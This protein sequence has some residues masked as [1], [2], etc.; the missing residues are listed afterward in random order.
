MEATPV[1][2]LLAQLKSTDLAVQTQALDLDSLLR[3]VALS[4]L[5]VPLGGYLLGI[6]IDWRWPSEVAWPS[7]L[8][9]LGLA[10][11]TADVWRWIKRPRP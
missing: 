11:G 6:L 1:K 7:G 3:R 2:R 4:M 5:G 8:L 10:L 9:F